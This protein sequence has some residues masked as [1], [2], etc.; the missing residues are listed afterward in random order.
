[1]GGDVEFEDWGD[2]EEDWGDRYEFLHYQLNIPYSNI[3]L[4]QSRMDYLE[5]IECISQVI[6]NHDVL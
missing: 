4:V 5:C 3:Q 1:M 6:I 2:A